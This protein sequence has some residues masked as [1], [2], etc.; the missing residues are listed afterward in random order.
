MTNTQTPDRAHWTQRLRKTWISVLFVILAGLAA[1]GATTAY[2]INHTVLETDRF[3]SVVAPVISSPEFAERSG[4][5]IATKTV[6]ALGVEEKVENSLDQL[7]EYLQ[8]I[9]EAV[10]I[11]PNGPIGQRLPALPDLTL[12]AEPITAKVEN[13]VSEL[14]TDL[15]SSSEFQSLTDAALRTAHT[16]AVA[17]VTGDDSNLPPAVTVD[18]DVELNF[19]PMIADAIVNVVAAG[20]DALGV[21]TP[22]VDSGASSEEILAEVFGSR[23][24]E[25]P[26]DFGRVVVITEEQLEPYRSALQTLNRLQWVLIIVTL[27]LSFAAVWTN[28]NRL[29]G[30]IWLGVGI[31]AFQLLSWPLTTTITESVIEGLDSTDT[32][33]VELVFQTATNELLNQTI[34]VIALGVIVTLFG[35]VRVGME[36]DD[37]DDVEADEE[38]M[39]S[40][41]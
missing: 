1:Q 10:G 13:R 25:V 18:G 29:V 14:T 21:D 20:A 27:L 36:G 34:V 3:M 35:M 5:V 23:G 37:A 40:L 26:D 12:L 31:V 39:S 6:E 38:A 2:W 15:I 30:T 41:S 9:P 11:D 19:R 17:V 7:N 4:E 32:G 24:I 28:P 16:V 22:R 8:A 33:L